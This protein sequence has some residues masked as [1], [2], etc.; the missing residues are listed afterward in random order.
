MTDAKVIPI[1]RARVLRA[2]RAV[3]ALTS[4]M[5]LD[6]TVAW[7]SRCGK[8][9]EE[10]LWFGPG[11]CATCRQLLKACEGGDDGVA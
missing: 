2:I 1:E 3:R 6:V 8:T 9:I 10:L 4:T 11:G 5:P 7:C